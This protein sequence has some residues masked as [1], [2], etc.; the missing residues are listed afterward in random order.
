MRRHLLPA[1]CVLAAPLGAQV[2]TRIDTVRAGDPRLATLGLAPKADTVD[3]WFV[4]AAGERRLGVVYVETVTATPGGFLVVEHNRRPDGRTLTLD[5]IEVDARTLA[6][7]WHA[8]VTP[9]GGRHVTFAGGR[10]TGTATDSAGRA[11]PVD[12][13]APAAIDYSVQGLVI[14]RLPLREGYRAVVETYDVT[15]GPQAVAVRVVGADTAAGRP[16][17]QVELDYGGFR[18][19]Q[20]IDRERRRTLRTRVTRPGMELVAEPRPVAAGGPGA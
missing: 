18:A 19:T 17:W 4:N 20:W 9:R 13:A 1:L 2:D 10:V 12:A 15:R 8:D 11:T 6:T 7:R 3:N 5:S 16:A 14:P